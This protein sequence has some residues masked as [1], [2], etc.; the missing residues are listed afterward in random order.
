MAHS[1]SLRPTGSVIVLSMLVASSGRLL[2]TSSSACL[3]ADKSSGEVVEL[4]A[5]AKAAPRRA[6][7]GGADTL[8]GRSGMVEGVNA[9]ALRGGAS[10]PAR[11]M[12]PDGGIDE[13]AATGPVG[14]AGGIAAGAPLAVCFF[15]AFSDLCV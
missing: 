8:E 4:V 13:V 14:T 11:S 3:I 1:T 6:G 5:I 15:V 9:G 10:A 2:C 12:T 7:E